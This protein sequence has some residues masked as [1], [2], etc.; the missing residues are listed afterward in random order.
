[1][2]DGELDLSFVIDYSNYPMTWDKGLERAVIAV[3]RVY[4]AVPAG[5]CPPRA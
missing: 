1:M 4:A 5:R 2:R 3:E